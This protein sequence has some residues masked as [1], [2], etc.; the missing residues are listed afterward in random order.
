MLV[1]CALWC[2]CLHGDDCMCW[3]RFQCVHAPTLHLGTF[4]LPQ[5]LYHRETPRPFVV[6]DHSPMFTLAHKSAQ[7]ISTISCI[8]STHRPNVA[9]CKH[10]GEL[11][12]H[13]VLVRAGVALDVQ[14]LDLRPQQGL[15]CT[16]HQGQ[17][18]M[19]RAAC[20]GSVVEGHSGTCSTVVFFISASRSWFIRGK[21]FMWYLPA[22][23]QN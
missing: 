7:L 10:F 2:L 9:A 8:T 15:R 12:D 13:V 1:R 17:H 3:Y 6:S 14:D 16:V 21:L 23:Q 19:S 5:K 11:H 18:C 4:S 20:S 22:A